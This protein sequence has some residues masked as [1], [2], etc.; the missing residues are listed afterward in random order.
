MFKSFPAIENLS[1]SKNIFGMSKESSAGCIDFTT[2][3][4]I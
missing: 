1:D 2:Y 4:F 3:G